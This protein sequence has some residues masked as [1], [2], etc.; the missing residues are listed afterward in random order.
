MIIDRRLFKNIDW[1]LLILVLSVVSL[2]IVNLYSA[3]FNQAA[4]RL[5]PL[6]IK[7]LYWLVIGLGLMFFMTTFDY[8]RLERL[9][10]PFLLVQ[11]YSTYRS[12]GGRESGSRFQT[13]ADPGPTGF[14][15]FGIGQSG[16][17]FGLGSPFLSPGEVRPPVL[18]RIRLPLSADVASFPADS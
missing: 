3:G 8:R 15:A 11:Y 9:A 5:T 14:S 2:G 12:D 10:Y 13:L 17:Y 6:Y 16:G 18:A 4:A 7:Q 1:I